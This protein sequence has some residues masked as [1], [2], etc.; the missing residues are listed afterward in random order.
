MSQEN[1]STTPRSL[2]LDQLE[3][4]P[5]TACVGCQNAVWHIANTKKGESLRVFCQLMHAIIDETM[6]VCDGTV[7]P[8]QKAE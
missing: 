5:K 3:V 6:T 2:T 8:P 4:S 1:T 7:M